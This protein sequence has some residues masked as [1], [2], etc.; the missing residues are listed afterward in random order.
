MRTKSNSTARQ[1]RR[2]LALPLVGF[3]IAGCSTGPASAPATTGGTP[4]FTQ[5]MTSTFFGPPAQ[6]VQGAVATAGD[7]VECPIVEVRQGASTITVYGAG[8]SNST[9]VRYQATIGQMARE[10]AVRGS[11]LNI[12]VGVQGRILMGPVGGAG[13][14]DIPLRL[15]LVQE[16]AQPKTI[17][18]KVYQVPVAVSADQTNVS[19]VHVEEDMT[20]PN[21]R[22]ADLDSYVIYVG[23][24]QAA[25]KEQRPQRKPRSS[26]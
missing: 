10:C 18:T 5:R 14:L 1:I 8:E 2:G 3:V 15:A 12:K 9:N 13:R 19:F 7:D 23:F 17:W 4:S 11:T 26:R 25:P 20:V 22:P 24:D 6:P 21:P 16:G